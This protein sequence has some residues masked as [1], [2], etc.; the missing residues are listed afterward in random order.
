MDRT[1]RIS[2]IEFNKILRS[3]T[4]DKWINEDDAAKLTGVSKKTLQNKVSAKQ[5]PVEAISEGVGGRFY[6]KEFLIGLKKMNKKAG[7]ETPAVNSN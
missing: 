3:A 2:S 4:L 1:L 5:I 7:A 6:D